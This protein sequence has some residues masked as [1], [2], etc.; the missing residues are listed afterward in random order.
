MMVLNDGETFTDLGGCKIIEVPDEWDE[1]TLP[2]QPRVRMLF[3]D[4]MMVP[5]GISITL[6]PDPRVDQDE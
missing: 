2:T 4:T 6:D 5:L 3:A 1:D